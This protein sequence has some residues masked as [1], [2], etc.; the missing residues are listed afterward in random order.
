M[1]KQKLIV[2]TGPTAVG[3]SKLSIALAKTIGGEIISADSMQVYKY[4]NIGTDKISPE[5]MDGVPHHLID[6]LEPSEDFNVFEFQKLVK[7][8]IEDI[9]SRG[10]VPII[11]GGTGFYIQ[12]VLYDID[13]TETDED[14]SYRK[15]LERRAL[16]VG[17]HVLHEELRAV[18]PESAEAIHEN[19]SKRVIRALEYYKKTGRPISQ[20]NKE[21]RERTSPYDF[22]YFVLTDDREVLYSRIDK[23]VDLM[24][25]EGL[26]AEVKE[27]SKLGIPRTATSMQG[28]GYREMFGYLDGE[29]DLDR[30]IYLI[31]RNTR[32]FAKRQLTWF[33]REEDV[34]WIDKRDFDR[35]EEKILKEIVRIY[36]Q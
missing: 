17:V 23:R 35:D 31:K 16:T 5:K 24:I 26:E 28:L 20:H 9:A 1:E 27:L 6:F 32:H 22:K 3:K 21:Q 12:A 13:F 2:L 25:E 14:D 19:N 30:A 34:I 29:Y 4:M 10:H 8:S 7:E 18:D 33:K 36:E 15:E 11:V